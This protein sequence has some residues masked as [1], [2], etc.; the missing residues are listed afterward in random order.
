MVYRLS[1]I[2]LI[3]GTGATGGS[4]PIPDEKRTLINTD[5]S[6]RRLTLMIFHLFLSA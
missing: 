2:V 4:P 5:A 3:Y 6:H 1:S